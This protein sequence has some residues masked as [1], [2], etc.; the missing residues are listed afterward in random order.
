MSTRRKATVGDGLATLPEF[1][2]RNLLIRTKQGEISPLIFNDVQAKLHLRLEDLR[3]RTGRVRALVLKARQPGV[4]TYVQCRFYKNLLQRRGVQ[5][6]I[7]TH[8]RD[9]TDVIFEIAERFHANNPDPKKPKTAVA[10]AKEICFA[11]IESGYRVGTAGSKAVGRGQTFQLFHGSEV[12]HWPNPGSHMAGL[13]QAVPDSDG[14]EAVLDDTTAS[15]ARASLAAQADLDVPSQSEAEAGT[16]TDE[17]VWTAERIKQ[18]ILALAPSPPPAETIPAGTMFD[19]AGAGT[20]PSGYLLCDGSSVSRTTYADLFAAIGETWGVGDGSTTFDLPDTRRRVAIG[21]GGT[22]SGVIGNAIGN[23]GG[24][25]THTLTIGEMPSHNHTWD[26]SSTAF[27]H[28]TSDGNIGSGSQLHIAFNSSTNPTGGNGSHN[29]V[30]PSYV[31][32]RIIKY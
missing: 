24:A 30:Q 31:V 19:F 14:T 23:I 5:A 9:A 32:Q 13:M 3:K 22:G 11:E 16:A 7:L 27:N 18:A 15:D 1:A 12:A 4:S 17:R 21:A 2:A 28:P 20:V 10:N 26:Y 8:Q 6:Y 25:E 29:I